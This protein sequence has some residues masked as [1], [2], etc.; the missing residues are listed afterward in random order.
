MTRYWRGKIGD[1]LNWIQSFYSV[2]GFAVIV[3]NVRSTGAS[4]GKWLYH[5]SRTETQD[6]SAVMDWII[7]QPWSDGRIIGMGHSCSANTA[8]WMAECKH[9]ALKAIVSRFADYDPYTDLYFPG[10]VP[11]AFMGRTWGMMVK[12]FIGIPQ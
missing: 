5:R 2:H 7:E 6:F 12:D 9:R 11:N 4:F 10:G 8:D 3:G 1:G